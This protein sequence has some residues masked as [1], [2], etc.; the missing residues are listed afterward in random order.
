[1]ADLPV[2]ADIPLSLISTRDIGVFA[3]LAFDR[4]EQLLGCAVPLAGDFLTLPQIAEVFG[5]HTRLSARNHHV[6]LEEVWAFDRHVAGLSCIPGWGCWLWADW[7]GGCCSFES[8]ST[9]SG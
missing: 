7:R 3:A 5:R 1:M 6:P 8:R 4:P 9:G 2:R